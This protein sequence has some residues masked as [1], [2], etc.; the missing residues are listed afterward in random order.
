MDGYPLLDLRLGLNRRD[1]HHPVRCQDKRLGIVADRR[2][3]TVVRRLRQTRRLTQVELAT[4]AQV[5]QGYLAALE[6]GLKTN[7]SLSTLTKLAR[8]LACR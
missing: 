1:P 4:R 3:R 2:D 5:S 6:G 8:P 7:P